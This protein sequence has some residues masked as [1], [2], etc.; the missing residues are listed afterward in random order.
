MTTLNPGI[1]QMRLEA[2]KLSVQLRGF[3]DHL[4][5]DQQ[6]SFLRTGKHPPSPEVRP[7]LSP[8]DAQMSRLDFRYYR[9]PEPDLSQDEIDDIVLGV[10]H[11]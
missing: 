6:V 8:L 11:G 10:R 2:M 9:A 3:V 5:I 1:R 4:W 7:D